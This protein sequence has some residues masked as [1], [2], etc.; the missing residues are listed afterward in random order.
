[1]AEGLYK[2][3]RIG[4]RRFPCGHMLYR[5]AS[6]SGKLANAW[7][8]AL[9]FMRVNNDQVFCSR[10][11]NAGS[12]ANARIIRLDCDRNDRARQSPDAGRHN[13]HRCS[14]LKGCL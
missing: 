2:R 9:A 14:G 3:G 13:Q 11:R 7:I 6:V 5:E 4:Q 10:N 8:I 1:M 12:R